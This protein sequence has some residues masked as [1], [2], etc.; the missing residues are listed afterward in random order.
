M[1]ETDRITQR[2]DELKSLIEEFGAKLTTFDSGIQAIY[3]SHE[4]HRN[5]TLN[6][7]YWEW[8]WL[9]PLLTEL[10]ERREEDRY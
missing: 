6:F 8:K 4:S 2:R 7:D 1:N 10:K 9:E 3:Y 5:E